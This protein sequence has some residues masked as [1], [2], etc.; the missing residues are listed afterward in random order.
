MTSHWRIVLIVAALLSMVAF[1]GCGQQTTT[2]GD[3]AASFNGT[4]AAPATTDFIAGSGQGWPNT[5]ED[6][7]DVSIWHDND[8]LYVKVT[9]GGDW[10]LDDDGEENLHLYAGDQ[11]SDTVAPGQFPYSAIGGNGEYTFVIP[12]DEIDSARPFLALHG[13]VCLPGE[14][15]EDFF[16]PDSDMEFDFPLKYG[17]NGILAGNVHL[18]FDGNNVIVTFTTTAPWTLCETHVYIGATPPTTHAAGQW[19]YQ[20]S[21]L[22]LGTVSDTFSI[23]LDEAGV[24]CDETIYIAFHATICNTNTGATETATGWNGTGDSALIG[25]H[26]WKRYTWFTVPCE[27]VPG[28]E[29]EEERCETAWGFD[30]SDADENDGVSGNEDGWFGNFGFS[31]WGW[32][33][34]YDF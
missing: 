14:F 4:E 20:H 27:F 10:I 32:F 30:S 23:P 31:R 17:K 33:L 18:S 34:R 26:K 12:R 7:G 16:G 25:D 15:S 29:L 3:R 11:A 9:M 19:N 8:N 1:I 2:L 24:A 5:G 28:G 21:P 6:V 22:P 13:D